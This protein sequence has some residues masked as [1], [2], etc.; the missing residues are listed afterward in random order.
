MHQRNLT[1]L[2]PLD[3]SRCDEIRRFARP[4]GVQRIDPPPDRLITCVC[5]HL[6]RSCIAVSIR[7]PKQRFRPTP[8]NFDNLFFA[9]LNLKTYLGIFNFQE[10]GMRVRV[11]ADLHSGVGNRA[12]L[13]GE[14]LTELPGQKKCGVDM[15]L[16]EGS[17]Q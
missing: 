2:D 4:I 1:W 16:H 17:E 3:Y 12:A 11:V 13:S 10:R 5:N 7:K 14:F 9:P 6:M 8:A 15:M